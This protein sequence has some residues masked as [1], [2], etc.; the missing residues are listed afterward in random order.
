M[1]SERALFSSFLLLSLSAAINYFGDTY[2]ISAALASLDPDLNSREA[3]RT[4]ELLSGVP[5]VEQRVVQQ[6]PK[7]ILSLHWRI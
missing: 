3:P 7:E 1:P 6:C 5:V 2:K 4:A